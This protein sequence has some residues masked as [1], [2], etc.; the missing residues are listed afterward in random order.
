MAKTEDLTGR[1]FGRWLVIEREPGYGAA[2]WRC[3]CDCGTERAVLARN[4]K[5]GATLSCG[6]LNRETARSNADDLSGQRF[7]RLT[8]LGRLPSDKNR[9]M[10]WRCQCD[11][12]NF[13]EATGKAL[14]S[15]RKAHCGCGRRTAWS[16]ITGQKFGSLTALKPTDERDADHGS[17]IWH[18]RCDC[19][20]ETNVSCND[21]K[22]G[23]VV[24]CGC[25]LRISRQAVNERLT[26]V[27]ETSIDA[28]RSK[29]LRVD[30]TTGVTGVYFRRGE[31]ISNI[32]LQGKTYFLGRCRTLEE[33]ARIR[34]EAEKLLHD[35]VVAFYDRWKQHADTDPDW[36][37]DNPVSISVEQSRHGE[38]SIILKPHEDK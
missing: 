18:C 3:R 11:C 38:V 13:C 31:F 21:L 28:L 34:R 1:R 20:R 22:S 30:N 25:R 35:D 23:N 9:R 27:D 7:G 33:A 36:A 5:S 15:G 16:D 17:V 32:T 4:L 8:V 29:K 6:C 19:G 24:S 14:R 37:K 12:G 10:R 2:K 26:H